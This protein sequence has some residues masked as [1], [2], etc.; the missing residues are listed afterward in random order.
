MAGTAGTATYV[1]WSAGVS[2]AFDN[3]VDLALAFNDNDLIGP[4]ETITFAITKS[5]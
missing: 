2:K 3:G 1:F 4:D 5:F